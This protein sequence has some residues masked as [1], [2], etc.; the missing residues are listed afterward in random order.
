MSFL[1]IIFYKSIK[2]HHSFK[3]NHTNHLF[4]SEFYYICTVFNNKK[5]SFN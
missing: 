5:K 1:L 3:K 2:K 4:L